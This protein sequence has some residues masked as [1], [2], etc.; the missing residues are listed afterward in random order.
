MIFFSFFHV[1]PWPA[2]G[3]WPL[4]ADWF[5]AIGRAKNWP[6]PSRD[7]PFYDTIC[8]ELNSM[9]IISQRPMI[10]MPIKIII[11]IIINGW[12]K[13]DDTIEEYDLFLECSRDRWGP[14]W[15]HLN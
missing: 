6:Q 2:N 8:H 15:S 9:P 12:H 11:I 14:N 1:S 10:I 7:R 5:F 3:K 4:A 13:F